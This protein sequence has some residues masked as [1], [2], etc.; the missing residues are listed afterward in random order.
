MKVLHKPWYTTVV[1]LY[2]LGHMDYGLCHGM[3]F[4]LLTLRW[5]YCRH[6]SRVPDLQCDGNSNGCSRVLS[7]K[8]HFCL[9]EPLLYL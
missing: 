9:Y 8:S 5:L 6:H 7:L 1:R 3:Y 2:V 4:T